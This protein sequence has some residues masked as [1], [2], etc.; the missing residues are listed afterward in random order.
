LNISGRYKEEY[1]TSLCKK[2]KD[3]K[4]ELRIDVDGK[5]PLNVLSGDIYSISGKTNNYQSSFIFERI[6]KIQKKNEVILI[7]QSGK[8]DPK[9]EVLNNFQVRIFLNSCPLI[10]DVSCINRFGIKSRFLCKYSSEYYR[11]VRLQNDYEEGVKP[12][13]SYDTNTLTSNY[14]DRTHPM[15]IID[16][17]AEHPEWMR[18]RGFEKEGIE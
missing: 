18:A 8:F 2:T 6:K 4:L 9:N 3:T 11:T 5:R 16:A 14:L 7:A 12:F 10:A 1:P 17:F 15:T 13:I